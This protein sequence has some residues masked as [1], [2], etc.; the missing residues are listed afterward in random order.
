MTASRFLS[1]LFSLHV[2]ENIFQLSHFQRLTL[3]LRNGIELNDFKCPHSFMITV[4]LKYCKPHRQ[5]SQSDLKNSIKCLFFF[6]APLKKKKFSQN[7]MT[8]CVFVFAGGQ[9]HYLEWGPLVQR[10]SSGRRLGG[11]ARLQSR[12]GGAEGESNE[13]LKSGLF[14]GLYFKGLARLKE[15]HLSRLCGFYL[16]VILC[17]LNNIF[18]KW[19]QHETSL[20]WTLLR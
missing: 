16:L 1:L 12:I 8:A 20:R 2:S 15:V 5:V 9:R 6:P 3:M 18:L 10:G 14:V 11:G 4:T 19:S 13:P 17:V 7:P